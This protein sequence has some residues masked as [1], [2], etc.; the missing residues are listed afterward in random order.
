MNKYTLLLVALHMEY[1]EVLVSWI[2]NDPMIVL[3]TIRTKYSG[4]LIND[5]FIITY[6]IRASICYQG[7]M[8]SFGDY[9]LNC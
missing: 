1:M 7:N 5:I 9:G 8:I 3:M 6:V 2:Y 4:V